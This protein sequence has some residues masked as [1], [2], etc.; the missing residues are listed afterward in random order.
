MLMNQALRACRRVRSLFGLLLVSVGLIAA[1]RAVAEVTTWKAP[2]GEALSSTYRVW[3]NGTSIPVYTA[4]GVHG[5]AYAFATF[6]FK[7]AVRVAITASST[8]D[9]RR[10]VVRPAAARILTET[11]G[12]A[13]IISLDAPRKLSIEPDGINNPL[14]LFANRPETNPPKQGDPGVIFFGPGIHKPNRIVLRSGETLYLAG[15]A[16]VK[17]AVIARQ[18]DHIRIRGRGILDGTDW[19]WTKGPA[20]HLIGIENCS[21]VTIEDVVLRGSFAW[22]LVPMR[23]KDVTIRNVKI[24]NSRVQNDDGINPCNSQNV[25]IEDCFVRTDDDCV[26]L[27]GLQHLNAPDAPVRGITVRNCVFWCDRARIFLFAHESQAPAIE[28]LH[29]HD[30]DVIHYVMTPFLL[31]PGELMPIRNA[32]FENFRIEGDGE[33]DFITLRPTVNQYMRVKK[34]GSIK[35]IVFKN[36]I[37]TGNH[38]GAAQVVIQGASEANR[39]DDVLFDNVVCYGRNL[40]PHSDNVKIGAFTGRIRF[41]SEGKN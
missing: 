35:G 27:K 7:G 13:L 37:V 40:N 2:E 36:I 26:A 6:D 23:C 22:T 28:D 20:G 16:V 34:P 21:D 5:G 25:L 15:G 9:L 41:E 18:A 29:Y 24:V 19:P 11:E 31:E 3:V 17:G 1:H 8:S 14:L 12:D 30:C 38:Q 32:R 4:R 33:H 10:A 39:V